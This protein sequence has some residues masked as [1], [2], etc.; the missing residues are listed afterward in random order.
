VAGGTVLVTGVNGLIGHA[1]ARRLHAAR[2][3]VAGTDVTLPGD[4]DVPM[5]A[6]DLRDRAAIDA[7]VARHRPGAIVHTGGISGPTV[8]PE[9]PT[10]VFDVN[11][12]GTVNVC[13]AARR[14]GVERL[15]F[16]SS[17]LGYGG[18]PDER[19]VTEET[20]FLGSEAYG[21]SKVAGEAIL[22][23][24]A[25]HG[26]D[27]VSLRLGPVYGPRRTASCVIRQMVEN[28][29][30]GRPTRIDWGGASR[31]QYL[32]LDDA[33]EA[34]LLAA[35]KRRLPLPA[36][37]VTGGSW[38]T[39]GEIAAA[40]KAALPAVDA[41]FGPAPHPYDNRVGPLRIDAAERDLGY[42]PR[43]S[44]VQGIGAYAAWLR[45]DR[46]GRRVAS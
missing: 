10:L 4:L 25:R 7:L 21:A 3:P 35:D 29:F 43:T 20:P 30:A 6:A 39:L 31:R 24:Y 2:R 37:N 14:H 28:A 46:S 13:D 19:P 33:V 45:A 27:A 8:A 36:Y 9:D 26:I 1:V 15:V 5:S 32:F 42:R 44:L 12:G 18:Q 41:V 34:I 40:A 22:R 23:A 17:I 11:V 16:L 38:D